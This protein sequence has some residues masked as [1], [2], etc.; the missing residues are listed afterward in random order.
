MIVSNLYNVTYDNKE[1]TGKMSSPINAIY[2]KYY[3]KN[4]VLNVKQDSA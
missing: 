1:M 4:V 3:P 2:I